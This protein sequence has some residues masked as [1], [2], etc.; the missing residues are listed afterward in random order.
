[1]M[2]VDA[3]T[4]PP[5][6]AIDLQIKEIENQVAHLVRSNA[7]IKEALETEGEDKELRAAIVRDAP[8]PPASPHYT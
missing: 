7:E 4:P 8:A 1:M 5:E 6:S 3:S 2:D